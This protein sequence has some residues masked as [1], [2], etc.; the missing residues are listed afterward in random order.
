MQKRVLFYEGKWYFLS[1]FSSFAI[2]QN[3]IIWMTVEHAYQEAKFSDSAIIEEIR[4]AMSAHDSK[5]IAQKHRGSVRADWD[6]IKLDVMERLLRMKIAQ[7]PYVHDKLLETGNAE[8][9]DDSPKDSFWGRGPDWQGLNH[10]GKLWMKLRD[11]LRE[12]GWEVMVTA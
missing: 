2:L 4:T 12:Q 3:G 8:L 10:L 6:D 5:E 1:N 7:H 9:I 11:E